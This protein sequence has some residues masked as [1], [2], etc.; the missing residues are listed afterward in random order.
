[1]LDAPPRRAETRNAASFV[2]EVFAAARLPLIHLAA[3]RAYNVQELAARLSHTANLSR[4]DAG[5]RA[6]HGTP[7]C[8]QCGREMV[9]GVGRD[10][11]LQWACANFPCCRAVQRH[12]PQPHEPQPH[13]VYER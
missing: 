8:S 2:D 12:E 11:A 4:L 3:Q 10:G 9:L 6:G 1:M 5:A 13:A 7:C